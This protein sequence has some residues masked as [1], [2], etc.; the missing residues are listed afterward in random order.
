[1][2]T[3]L[4]NLGLTGILGK[5]GT[6]TVYQGKQLSTGRDVA[7]KV[8]EADFVRSPEDVTRFINEAKACARFRHNNIVRVY[9]AGEEQGIYYFV[10]ELVNGYTFATYLARKKQV[11]VEDVLIIL[12]SVTEALKYAWQKFRV[13]HCDLKP[14]NIMVDSSGTI[15]LMDLGISKS[16]I[17]ATRDAADGNEEIMGTPAYMSPD[18]IYDLSDIDCR[19]DIYSL[20]ATAYHLLTGTTLFPGKTDQQ[21]IDSHVGA[22]FARD[23]RILAPTVPRALAQILNR[24]LAKD[25]NLRYPNWETLSADFQRLYAGETLLATPLKPGESSVG[26]TLEW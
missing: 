4:P 24:M 11:A 8:L 21:V 5:G 17:T 9:D 15:K 25:R 12:E 19:A 16:L 20:G 3:Q 6:A 26:F 7:V 1:M 10:M 18:Q 14:D 2:N 22:S 13:V 23:P